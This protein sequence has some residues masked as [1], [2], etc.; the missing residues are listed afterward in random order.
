ME[1]L[2]PKDVG[3]V[4]TLVRDHP[5]LI[6][7]GGG[8][9]P[10]LTGGKEDGVL[11]DFSALRGV[12]EYQPEEYTFTALAGTRL[13]DIAQMLAQNGQ[14]LPFDPPL[15]DRGATLG[16]TT[17]AGLSGSG[18]YRYGG[19]RDFVLAVQFVD[20]RGQLVRSGGK[21]VKNAAG[22]DLPKFMVGSLGQY[23]FLTELTFK[24]FPQPS[25]YLTIRFVYPTMEE[26]LKAM[27]RLDGLSLDLYALDLEPD[28]DSVALVARLGGPAASFPARLERIRELVGKQAAG[29]E[30]IE[31]AEEVE[32]WRARREFS[33]I[34][35]GW[36]LVK[37]PLT[38]GRLAVLDAHLVEF[39]AQ[40][41]YVAGG[42]MAWVAWPQAVAALDV[43][44]SEHNLSG[45]LLVRS[46]TNGSR[47]DGRLGVRVGES[48]ARRIKAALDPE[49]KFGG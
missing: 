10:A 7:A 23:G 34:P 13:S 22:F 5:C 27:K 38:P 31:G 48:F 1:T 26:A 46:S 19:V 18:R 45:L 37:V 4:Q 15:V 17:A 40:R 44:L 30:L 20:G 11:V 42:N 49:G 8:T 36:D 2:K 29:E 9:K 41:R 16:G 33:W 43:L 3:E 6:A 32:F 25:H 28:N 14:Y 12:L 21:V 35:Q 47:V 39:G 24:V